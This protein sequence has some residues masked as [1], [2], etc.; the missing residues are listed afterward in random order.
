M[1]HH[2]QKGKTK[3]MWQRSRMSLRIALEIQQYP[4]IILNV[5][6]VSY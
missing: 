3:M 4:V 5:I 2:Q 6:R 1:Q